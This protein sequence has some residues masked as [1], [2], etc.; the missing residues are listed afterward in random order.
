MIDWKEVKVID[1]ADPLAM[2]AADYQRRHGAK[3]VLPCRGD[4]LGGVS[5]EGAYIYPPMTPAPQPK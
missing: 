2:A 5:I 3:S 1:S 4:R